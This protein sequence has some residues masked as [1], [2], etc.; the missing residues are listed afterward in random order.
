MTSPSAAGRP[1]IIRR[2]RPLLGTI[3]EITVVGAASP[4][5]TRALNAAFAAIERVQARMSYHDPASELSAINRDAARRPTR[6]SRPLADVLRAAVALA[7]ETDGAFDPT[8]APVLAGWG[9]LPR[10]DGRTGRERRASWRDIELSAGRLV[11]FHAPLHLDLGGI[12]KGFA[13][14]QA[15]ACLRQRGVPAA[16]V[17][18][19]GDLRAFGRRAWPIVVRDPSQPGS[20]AAELSLRNAAVATSAHYF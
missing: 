18:A 4:A 11:R 10:L 13:V 15:I 5:A 2:A 1:A 8:I 17:N 20:A 14:D 19:G 3:V 7:Q 12:A 6:I 9:L 16:L